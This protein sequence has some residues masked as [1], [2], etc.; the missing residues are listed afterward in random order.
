MGRSMTSRSVARKQTD[1]RP[2]LPYR[3]QHL[4]YCVVSMPCCPPTGKPQFLPP[5]KLDA[6]VKQLK[7]CR[8]MPCHRATHT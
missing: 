8:N 4:F 7:P 5:F 2:P 6:I 1:E 3:V